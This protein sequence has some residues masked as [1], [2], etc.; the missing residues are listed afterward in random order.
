MPPLRAARTKTNMNKVDS[1]TYI[2]TAETRERQAN[3]LPENDP[4]R[5]ELL[6]DAAELRE[7][8]ERGEVAGLGCMG[9]MRCGEGG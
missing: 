4:K 8:A 5:A 9:S 3:A 2:A 6:Q 1:A 7:I